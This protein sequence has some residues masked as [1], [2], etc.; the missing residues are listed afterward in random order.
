MMIHMQGYFFLFSVNARCYK[1]IR[2]VSYLLIIA[3]AA[4]TPACTGE[5]ELVFVWIQQLWSQWT[6]Q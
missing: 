6:F 4:G 1:V 5:L 2:G 3:P